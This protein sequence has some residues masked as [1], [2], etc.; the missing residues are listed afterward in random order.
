MLTG[1]LPAG[2]VN[3]RTLAKQQAAAGYLRYDGDDFVSFSRSRRHA[4]SLIEMIVVLFIIVGLLSLLYP[5]LQSARE[6]ARAVV[7]LYRQRLFL[8]AFDGVEV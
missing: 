1:A 6:R 7:V 2:C 8:Q 4:F 5:A 3:N